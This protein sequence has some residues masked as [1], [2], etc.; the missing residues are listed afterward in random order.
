ME[1]LSSQVFAYTHCHPDVH[2]D[3]KDVGWLAIDTQKGPA[4]LSNARS[5][6]G[7]NLTCLSVSRQLLPQ[8]M[9]TV[10]SY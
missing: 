10:P 7:K 8:G 6:Q 9:R 2:N 3:M 4:A 5:L 1:A